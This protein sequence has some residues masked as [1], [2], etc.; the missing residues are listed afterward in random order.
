VIAAYEAITTGT[1]IGMRY[2]ERTSVG[3]LPLPKRTYSARA[4]ATMATRITDTT[5]IQSVS[6]RS[7]RMKELARRSR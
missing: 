4:Y 3:S 5:L 6:H 7:S 2:S 1:N